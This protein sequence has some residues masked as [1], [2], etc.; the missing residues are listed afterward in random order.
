D[1][2]PILSN[3][4]QNKELVA[5]NSGKNISISL[6]NSSNQESLFC[7]INTTEFRSVIG[8][9]INNSLEASA[10]E[11]KLTI[12]SSDNNSFT[13]TITDNGT[14]VPVEIRHKLFEKNFTYGKEKGSGIGLHHAKKYLESWGGKIQ[15]DSQSASG[16][17]SFILTLKEFEVPEISI[18]SS[19]KILVLDDNADDRNRLLE[20]LHSH[21]PENFKGSVLDFEEY[22]ELA[23]YLNTHI[24]QKK[25]L[26]SDYD[27]GGD[28]GTGLDLIKS[29]SLEHLSFLVQQCAE[30][31]ISIIPKPELQKIKIQFID[32]GLRVV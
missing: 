14:G 16:G 28:G 9:L 6:H 17:S 31:N 1:I 23:A 8:N 5:K 22:G 12:G 13:I 24:D 25:I 26:F 27:L 20:K 30:G 15:L 2:L 3:V 4:I 11:V 21:L 19:T 29:F 32:K 18:C 7:K 10:T